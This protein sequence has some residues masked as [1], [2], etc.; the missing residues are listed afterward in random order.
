MTPI[1]KAKGHF[2]ELTSGQLRGPINVPE[3][4]IDVYYSPVVSLATMSEA[5]ELQ[6]KG[7]MVEA[8]AAL[9]QARALDSDGKALFT[10]SDRRTLVNAVDPAIINR[11]IDEMD[12]DSKEFELG[13]S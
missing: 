5:M 1:E 10:K 12:S 9:L 13:N 8:F 2:R 6:Q 4:D 3:W 11:I 7:K